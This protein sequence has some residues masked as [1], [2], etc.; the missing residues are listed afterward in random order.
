MATFAE[1]ALVVTLCMPGAGPGVSQEAAQ[2]A[3]EATGAPC[4]DRVS[5]PKTWASQNVLE[6]RQDWEQC[7]AQESDYPPG[8]ARC[9]YTALAGVARND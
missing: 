6:A 8:A 7:K 9:K 1:I 3:L 4:L 2:G 5:Y